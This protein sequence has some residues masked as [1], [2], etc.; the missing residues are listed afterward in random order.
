MEIKNC[1][2]ILYL[3]LFFFIIIPKYNLQKKILILIIYILLFLIVIIPEY[4]WGGR[5][6]H[7]FS[8][9]NGLKDYF[10]KSFHQI[11]LNKLDKKIC[12]ENLKLIHEIFSE[13]NIPFWLSEGTSLGF[14]R[15]NDFIGWDDDVD[16]ATN[17]SNKEKVLEA[18]PKLIKKGF[19]IS[20]INDNYDNNLGFSITVLR[21]NEI[22]DIDFIKKGIYCTTWK[23][24]IELC[25]PIVPFVQKF[26]KITIQ[27]KI[28]NI[29]KDEYFNKL[30][31]KDW[32]IPLENDKGVANNYRYLTTTFIFAIIKMFCIING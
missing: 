10:I 13:E 1:F 16:I 7:K 11:G 17:F 20:K 22:V 32:R 18:L 19:R 31:G 12:Y 21:K 27:N 8:H 25:D 26:D 5:K 4:Y 28:Y 29:P 15:D 9:Y 14:K 3:I 23:Y 30:Y 24:G 2:L 6:Y